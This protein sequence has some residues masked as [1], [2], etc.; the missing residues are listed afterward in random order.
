MLDQA[1]QQCQITPFVGGILLAVRPAIRPTEHPVMVSTNIHSK[2]L[3]VILQTLGKSFL[4]IIKGYLELT[5]LHR[6]SMCPDSKRAFWCPVG[7]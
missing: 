6:R 5:K 2:A 3:S 4:A 7:T 1:C